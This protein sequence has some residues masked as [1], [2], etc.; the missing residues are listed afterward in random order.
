[1]VKE[2]CDEIEKWWCDATKNVEMTG[3]TVQQ[4]NGEIVKNSRMN[5]ET[6]MWSKFWYVIIK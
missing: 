2:Y 1:M 4:W 5:G 3:E 6:N